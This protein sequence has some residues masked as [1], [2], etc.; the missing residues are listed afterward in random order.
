[1]SNYVVFF[2][3]LGAKKGGLG[4]QRVKANFEDIEREAQIAD[5]L[6][7]RAEED[8]KKATEFKVEEEETQVCV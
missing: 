3:Q 6:K 2:V 7:V 4:A 5:E 8:A 1:M